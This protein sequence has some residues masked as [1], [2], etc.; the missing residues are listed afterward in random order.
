MN[1]IILGSQNGASKPTTSH[2]TDKLQLKNH[3]YR[4]HP[5]LQPSS[6]ET[7]CK[8]AQQRDVKTQRGRVRHNSADNTA[9]PATTRQKTIPR[10][11]SLNGKR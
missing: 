4:S 11:S 5:K 2:T 9:A 7:R 3:Q 8:N 1:I 6:A 10:Q